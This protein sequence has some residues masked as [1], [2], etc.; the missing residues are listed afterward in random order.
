MLVTEDPA[1]AEIA[2]TGE[3]DP[4]SVRP[5]LAEAAAEGLDGI[6]RTLLDAGHGR[7]QARIGGWSYGKSGFA[8]CRSSGPPL[9]QPLGTM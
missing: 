2:S 4:A 5:R 1:T 7:G 8:G 6:R 3:L 9:W